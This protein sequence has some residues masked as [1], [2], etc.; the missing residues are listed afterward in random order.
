MIRSLGAKLFLAN[1]GALL[2]VLAAFAY[3][4]GIQAEAVANQI[5]DDLLMRRAQ[6]MNG[7]IPGT[8]GGPPMPPEMMPGGQRQGQPGP[9]GEGRRRRGP[10]GFGGAFR[11]LNSEGQVVSPPDGMPFDADLARRSLA[12]ETVFATVVTEGQRLRV[13]SMPRDNPVQGPEVIQ[14]AQESSSLTLFGEAQWRAALSLL[15]VVVLAA[16]G[17][18]W[19]LARIVLRPV[20]VI[21]ESANEIAAHPDKRAAIPVLAEDEIGRLAQSLNVMT[22]RL[23]LAKEQSET[24]LERQKRFSSDAA[25]ELRTPLAAMTLS[26]DNAL[27]PA[28]TPTEKQESLETFRRLAG[29][30]TR[31]T[32]M[33]LALARLDAQTEPLALASVD[34][35]EAV[36]EAVRMAGLASDPRLAVSVEGV[37]TANR[38]ALIQILR[39]LIEN[40]ATHTPPDGQIVISGNCHE[41]KVQDSGV[42]IAPEHLPRVFDRFYRTDESRQRKTGGYGLG[43]SIVAALAQAMDAS[44]RAESRPGVGTTFFVT[45]AKPAESSQNPHDRREE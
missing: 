18:A 41:L 12:G 15:P 14:V 25:H 6:A 37:A 11:V 29:N 19:L 39:N 34:L 17:A 44:V 24:A 43:L 26:A 36:L 30:M 10:E 31:L 5:L 40:A 28:A 4:Q 38:D 23:Q 21:A 7:A 13:L 1:L 8:P 16:A 33:L 45:F 3:V 27:H 42:G 20:R 9:F 32:E 35:D 2:V 22:D